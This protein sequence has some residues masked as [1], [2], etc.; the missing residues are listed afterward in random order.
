MEKIKKLRKGPGRLFET[1]GICIHLF[2]T[3]GLFLKLSIKL[4][5]L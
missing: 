2:R 5:F 4:W 3:F 1:Y